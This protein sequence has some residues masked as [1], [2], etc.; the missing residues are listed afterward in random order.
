MHDDPTGIRFRRGRVL[1]DDP[2]LDG[3][4]TPGERM[5]SWVSAGGRCCPSSATRTGAASVCDIEVIADVHYCQ[6][7]GQ[8]DWVTPA[9]NRDHPL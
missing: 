5:R 9:M 1:L 4:R 6:R 7:M 2:F 3:C 8:A